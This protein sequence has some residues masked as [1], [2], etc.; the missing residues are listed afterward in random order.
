MNE[1]RSETND[2]KEETPNN[3]TNISILGLSGIGSGL[4]HNFGSNK[5]LNDLSLASVEAAKDFQIEI[6]I[7]KLEKEI[8]D[9]EF[10]GVLYA[11]KGENNVV[12][13]FLA[14]VEATGREPLN[15]TQIVA[16]QQIRNS[17][18]GLVTS[19]V[20][21]KGTYDKINEIVNSKYP[22]VPHVS[23]D[24][25][26]LSHSIDMTTTGI[27]I[28]RYIHN[29]IATKYYLE[30]GSFKN[31]TIPGIQDYCTANQTGVNVELS[32]TTGTV[33]NKIGRPVRTDFNLLTSL[34]SKNNIRGFN[35]SS[36]K[37][38]LVNQT[39]VLDFIL[40]RENLQ[41]TGQDRNIAEP[42]IKF[43][44]FSAAG[45]SLSYVLLGLINSAIFTNKETLKQLIIANDAGPLNYILNYKGDANAL[46]EKIS[47]R[48]ESAQPQM[49]QDII[50]THFRL[51]PN[52]VLEVE[53][54]G[55]DYSFMKPF[56][57]LLDNKHKAAANDLILNEASALIGYD[58][59]NIK[60]L[61]NEGS[62]IPIG[63]FLDGE[64]N[65]RDLSEIDVV[66]ITENTNDAKLVDDWNT[67]NT[68][69]SIC[70]GCTGKD[71]YTL[72]LE[73]L[74]KLSSMLNLEIKITGKAASL[75]LSAEFITLLVDGANRLG[76]SP[77]VITPNIGYIN[78][79]NLQSVLQ[80]F[81]NSAVGNMSFGSQ[82]TNFNNTNTNYNNQFINSYR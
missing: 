17:D 51:N 21:V 9:G 7:F 73:V 1:T 57:A 11:Y 60:V 55:A 15:V 39:G 47:F 2:I 62:Y 3:G 65:V 64:Q 37:I 53:L 24:G 74:N 40:G 30:V 34:S 10:G 27:S 59:P 16:E 67:S 18:A 52:F 81:N 20:F 49:I 78:N 31:P 79:S 36:K 13:S 41:Y 14:I 70:M 4:L 46:G 82:N 66:F 54:Y 25:F 77:A 80:S 76:Y 69:T 75:P 22:N 72:K 58:L 44:E 42:I 56:V 68:S 50:N 26:V 61:A 6:K 12:Y 19:D 35:T 48:D 45:T 33:Y 71:P 38:N 32:L 28:A 23:L 29:V 43:N 63:E 5:A 8:L